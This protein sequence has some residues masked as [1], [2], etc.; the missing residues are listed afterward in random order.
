MIYLFALL[1]ALAF[2]IAL[3]GEFKEQ[4]KIRRMAEEFRRGQ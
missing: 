1:A 4:Q 2:G 3:L